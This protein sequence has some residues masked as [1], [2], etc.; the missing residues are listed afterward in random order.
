MSE[1]GKA[2]PLL[3]AFGGSLLWTGKI[4]GEEVGAVPSVGALLVIPRA[5]LRAC[6]LNLVTSESSSALARTTRRY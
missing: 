2:A 3:D 4:S 5:Q 1:C 6:V